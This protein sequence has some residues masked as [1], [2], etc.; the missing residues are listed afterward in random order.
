ME[1][2]KKLHINI[3]FSDALE[4]MPSYVKFIKDILSQK[5]RLEDF[6]TVNLTEECSAILQRK[7]PQKLEDLGSFTIPCTIDNAIF[8]RALC[9]LGGSINLMPLSIFKRLGLGEA[10]LTTV[11]LQLADRSL[12]HPRGVIEDVLVKV[13]KFIFPA[14]FIVLDMEEDKEIPIILGRP[15]L[16]IGRSMIDVQRGE[17]KLRVQEDEVKFNVFKAMRHPTKSD[18]CFMTETAE[19]IVSSQSGL[20]DPL[21]ASLVQ[22]DSENLGEE[23]EEYVKWMDSFKP[24]RRKYFE[25]LGENTKKPVPYVEQLPKMEQKPL[26]IH[27]KYA[28]HGAA[29]T[30]PVIILASLKE[31]EEEKLLRVLRDHKNALGWSLADLKGIRP[32]MCMHRI[33]L[34]DGHKPSVEAQRRLNPT[35]KEVVRKEVLKW[36]DTGVIYPIS[37]N[38]WVSP[39]QVVPKK[40]GTT[41]IR[42]ENNILLPSRTVTRWRICIDYRKLNKATRKNHFPLPFLDQML[43]RLAG[44]EYY[45]FLDGYSGYNQI[46]IA[47]EDQEKTTFTCPYGTFSFRRMPFELCNARG[48]FQRCMM[49]IFSDMVEKTIEVFM[50]DFSIFGGSFDNCLENLRSV[51]I[52][53]EET[54]LALNWEKCHFMVQ[55][56]IILGHRISARGIEVD[57]AKIEAIEKLP[58]P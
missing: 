39:V 29:S 34:E 51:L 18:T 44:H 54:N 24:N 10:R 35:M 7:L 38:A 50:D 11:T 45:F 47:P 3:L 58:P 13:D 56:G 46:A 33:L 49:A 41:V 57:R 25:L 43:D 9:D 31:L 22:S 2:F 52:R 32:S 21:E 42:T 4:Q 20:T 53:C 37:N 12:K 48:T 40:G 6:K 1:V 16:T 14:D 30:L 28:Y 27:L 5:R 26:P 19:A 23:V 36:L 55:E 15:F 8:E 17:L